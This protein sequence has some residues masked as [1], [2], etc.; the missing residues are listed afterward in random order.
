[1][2]NNSNFGGY[3][4][5]QREEAQK[6][7]ELRDIIRERRLKE[8]AGPLSEEE[9]RA[10]QEAV[11]ARSFGAYSVTTLPNKPENYG[12]GPSKSTRVA[13]HKFVPTQRSKDMF[14]G[15]EMINSG[16]VYVRFARPS[17]QQGGTAVY[18]YSN[19]SVVE[20]EAFRR[21]NSKG[22]FINNPLN[23][24]NPTKIEP[25][26]PEFAQYCQDL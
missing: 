11:E 25:T 20:Y 18:R 7:R 17:Q 10:Y 16:N 2:A 1:M 19:V 5:A 14:L 26:D 15:H 13:A 9:E 8:A 23:T 12:R 22:R 3:Y 24:K 6:Q 21:S 4:R